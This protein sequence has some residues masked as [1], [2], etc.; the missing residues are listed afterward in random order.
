MVLV[1]GAAVGAVGTPVKAGDAARLVRFPLLVTAPV[2]LALVVTV[3]ALAAVT[4]LN[5]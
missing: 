2:K 1:P 5:A 4:A 3:K